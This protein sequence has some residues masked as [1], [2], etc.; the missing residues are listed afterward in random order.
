MYL[1]LLNKLF[2]KQYFKNSFIIAFSQLLL[3][4]VCPYPNK[5]LSSSDTQ[6]KYIDI[7]Y[8]NEKPENYFILIKK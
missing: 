7:F 6:K 8:L 3:Q 5:R 1:K 2:Y 4:N